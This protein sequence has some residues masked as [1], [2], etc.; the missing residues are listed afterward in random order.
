MAKA[1]LQLL[2]ESLFVSYEHD[3]DDDT[4]LTVNGMLRRPKDVVFHEV[5]LHFVLRDERGRVLL[6]EE[7]ALEDDWEV[8]S[9]FEYL[10]KALFEKA[11]QLEI[12]AEG[13][14]R[15]RS[16]GVRLEISEAELIESGGG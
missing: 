5:L 2:P 1:K 14:V 6:R 12:L 16:E 9:V 8:F 4:K 11:S 15:M 3:E 10:P 13:Q 7:S